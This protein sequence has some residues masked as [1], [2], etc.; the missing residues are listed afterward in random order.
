MK[1]D[2]EYF[3]KYMVEHFPDYPCK[4]CKRQ[5]VLTCSRAIHDR[6]DNRNQPCFIYRRWFS[7]TWKELKKQFGKE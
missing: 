4:N 7:R 5:N 1:K 6:G 3:Y 2:N